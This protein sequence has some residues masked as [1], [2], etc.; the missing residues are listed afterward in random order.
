MS[1]AKLVL[2]CLVWLVLLGAGVFIYRIIYVP[3]VEEKEQAK[4]EEVLDQTSG[5]SNYKHTI[6]FGL[7]GFSGYAVMRSNEMKQLLRSQGI[8]L[9][10]EDDG[11]NYEKRLEDLASGE[12][13]MAAFPIDALLKA[14]EA[15]GS[16]PATI[17]SI[18]DETAGAD[19]LVAY[20]SK[21]PNIDA[22]NTSST[23]FVL[24]ENSPSETL[25]RFLMH[26]LKL[27]AVDPNAFSF[28]NSEKELIS[29]YKSSM[30]GGN[31]VFV[32]WEP[33][34]SELLSN[35]QMSVLFSSKDQS[36]YI[37]DTIVVSR[38]YLIKNEPVVRQVLES[39]FTALYK[40]S[41]EV[42]LQSLVQE[43][44]SLDAARAEALVKGVV[45]KNTQENFAHFGLRRAAVSHVED[46][47]DRVKR[48]LIDTGGLS[49]DPT[50]GQ[51]SRLYYEQ[52]LSSLRDDGFHPGQGRGT[53][54][55]REQ[56][57]LQQLSKQ[58]WSRLEPVGTV[59]VPPLIYARGTA[60][61]TQSS[62][63]KLES[64]SE[65]LESFP[66]FYLMVRG[67][68]SSKGN[69]EANKK[70]AK[71]RAEAALQYLVEQGV[72]AAKMKAMNGEITGQ[73]S[74]TFVLGEQP[75]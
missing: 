71:Q 63:V 46:M 23:R 54:E 56:E 12:L 26:K 39:Y 67:N 18:I 28:V 69:A 4:K 10:L 35:D 3:A 36:G 41:D 2:A 30:P 52:I 73:T 7:D 17:I 34:V 45:W 51:S 33:V 29:R 48:V 1:K 72:P 11:A 15:K 70:L 62:K 37:V 9:Q 25:V 59:D 74:V 21:F 20:K 61:L 47:I 13:Q 49:S 57:Q 53:E 42:K 32:T 16:M 24:V 58:Q 55:I 22:L 68:A 38:D 50:G 60:K 64:L 27:D 5:S 19:A 8:R 43:D 14:M 31:E 44:A 40:F 75:Y 6:G 66:T 65:T